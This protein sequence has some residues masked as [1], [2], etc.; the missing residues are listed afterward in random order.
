MRKNPTPSE[1][2]FWAKTRNRKFQDFKFYRQYI[3]EHSEIMGIKNFFIV[4]FYC[5][6]LKL[7]IEIDGRI[8]KYKIKYDLARDEILNGMGYQIIRF[9]NNEVLSHW[10]KVE[11]KLKTI[12][13]GI[14]QNQLKK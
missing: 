2:K 4:D 13:N 3:V 8:H 10:E 1:A 11:E 6:E 14:D 5:H 9:S 12:I 7:I